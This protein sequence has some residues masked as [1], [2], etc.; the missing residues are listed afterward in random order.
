MLYDQYPGGP[1]IAIDFQ[2]EREVETVRFAFEEHALHLISLGNESSVSDY[3]RE[4][5][6]RWEGSQKRYRGNSHKSVTEKLRFLYEA[7]ERRVDEILA[8]SGNPDRIVDSARRYELGQNA[9][10][11][12]ESIELQ[13]SMG[14]ELDSLLEEAGS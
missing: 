8:E 13:A 2:G 12:L 11:L 5:I 14:A 1:G 3:Q 9:L 6:E 7:T 10:H 4:V